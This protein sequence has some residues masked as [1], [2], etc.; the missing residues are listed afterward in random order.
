MYWNHRVVKK[1]N[2]YSIHEVY[3]DE[4]DKVAFMTERSVEPHGESLESLKKDLTRML[5][6]CDKDVLED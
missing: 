5:A 6:A 2:Q 3:Y 1:D 4:E